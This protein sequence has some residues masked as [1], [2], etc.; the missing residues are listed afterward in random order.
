MSDERAARLGLRVEN[1]PYPNGIAAR[2][3]YRGD[4]RIYHGEPAGV[5]PFLDGYEAGGDTRLSDLDI[6]RAARSILEDRGQD[7]ENLSSAIWSLGG[8]TD[9]DGGE[10]LS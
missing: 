10:A 9:A 2:A 4:E 5:R 8:D 6:L 3:V 7:I 1:E